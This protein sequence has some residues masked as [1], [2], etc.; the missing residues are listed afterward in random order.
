MQLWLPPAKYASRA[1]FTEF[2]D[3]V[4]RRL[5]KFP[6]V[7]E[8]AIVNT[9]PFLGWRHSRRRPLEIREGE[10]PLRR[11]WWLA[12]VSRILRPHNA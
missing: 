2:Y 9:R 5:H 6:E 8:A 4:L 1:K 12:R 3:D 10:D 11:R 7:R